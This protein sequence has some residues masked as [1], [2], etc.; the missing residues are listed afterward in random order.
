MAGKTEER[1]GDKD[2]PQGIAEN[3]LEVV[4][5]MRDLR[6]EK[7]CPWDKEQNH[8]SLRKYLVE[9]AYE[10]I[11]AINLKDD[12]ALKEELGDLLLQVIFHAQIAEERG[13]F[14][15]SHVLESLRDKLRRRHPHVFGEEKLSTS[16]EVLKNWEKLKGEEK[17]KGVLEGVP[18]FLPALMYAYQLQERAA[19]VGFDWKEVDS[20]WD[21]VKEE[22]SELAEAV[23]KGEG[24]E[25]E[26]GDILFSLVNLSRHLDIDPEIALK[27]ACQKFMERFSLIEREAEKE[28][29]KVSDLTLKEM[30]RVWEKSK[31]GR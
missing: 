16:K 20:V 5:L 31:G 13:A 11:D 18:S 4:K 3:F 24:I 7:G 27:K 6:G 9:E 23:K 10:V 1:S 19:R 2:L 22:I 21:K 26:I 29:K 12:K 14:N 25:Q 15:I 28:G 8:E 17:K 30:D